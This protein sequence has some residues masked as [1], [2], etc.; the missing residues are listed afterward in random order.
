MVLMPDP[1]RTRRRVGLALYLIGLSFGGLL[2][3]LT[4]V[5]IPVATGQFG[6]LGLMCIGAVLALPAGAAYLTIPRL[7]DRYDPEPW[8]ALIACL[9]WGGIAATGYS[10]VINTLVSSLIGGSTGEL[11]ATVVSAPI[12]EEGFKGLAIFGVAYFL[13]REFDGVVDG[14]IY[15]TFTAIGFAAI[16]NVIYYARAAGHDALGMTFVIR[17][18]IAPW[19][20][21]VYTS[22]TGIGFGVARETRS[23]VLRWTAPLLGY[24]GAVALHAIWNGS[25]AISDGLGEGG[26]AFF[27]CMLPVW[28]L[29][30]LVFLVL[31]IF[32]VRRR[33]RIIREYLADE[34]ALGN[35]TT[36]EV[37]LVCS[38]FGLLQARS[39]YGKTGVLFVRAA[40]RLALSKWHTVRAQDTQNST[41]SMGFIVPLRQRLAELRA[42]MQSGAR[43]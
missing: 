26:G 3:F 36:D 30:V 18:L 43:R 42:Q 37:D 8:Y 2:L 16:E 27:V 5:G 29:F 28:L 39:R 13:R 24:F 10:A 17:G 35:L 32:L 6:M 19:G 12:V 21:P 20:H 1:E 23:S 31:V 4:F 41:V 7:L 40:A 15:A 22:M 34:V 9:V 14:I 38:A 11:V 33:G 25:A